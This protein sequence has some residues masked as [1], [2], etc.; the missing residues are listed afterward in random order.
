MQRSTA[1]NEALEKAE[2]QLARMK[3]ARSFGE[4]EEAW[5]DYLTALERL[6]N[7]ASAHFSRSPKW[8]GWSGRYQKDRAKDELI[9]YLS[10]ARDAHEHTIE[11]ISEIAGAALSINP[12][13]GGELTIIEDLRIDGGHISFRPVTPVAVTLEPAH[14][15]MLPATTRGRT[16]PVPTTHLGKPVTDLSVVEIAALGL[17]Y[18]KAFLDAA[19]AHFYS[20]S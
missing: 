18:Y 17:S 3:A 12:V 1:P 9:C 7:K 16:Y 5:I 14:V 6:W 4:L 8:G 10:K 2:K 19:E 13:D 11:R 20:T 15:R